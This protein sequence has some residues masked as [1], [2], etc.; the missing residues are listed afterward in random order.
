MSQWGCR[1]TVRCLLKARASSDDVDAKGY[2]ALLLAAAAGH[3]DALLELCNYANDAN[4]AAHPPAVYHQMA[5]HW[6]SARQL[7]REMTGCTR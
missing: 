5:A 3:R 4:A 1:R 7:A 2:T 6:R